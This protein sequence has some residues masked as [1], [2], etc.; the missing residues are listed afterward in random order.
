MSSKRADGEGRRG[1]SL[2]ARLAFFYTISATALLLGAM[3]ILYAAVIRHIDAEDH[4]YLRDKLRAARA[5]LLEKKA[6]A[7]P[8]LADVVP[9]G[10]SGYFVRVLDRATGLVVAE[11]PGG[12][13]KLPPSVFP[14]P[15]ADGEIPAAGVEFRTGAGQWFLLASAF[16]EIEAGARTPVL[17]QI[18]QDR[19]DDKAFTAE[20]RRLLVTVLA[21]GI[22]AAA[23]IAWL[24]AR[25][26]L[27]PLETMTRDVEKVQASHLHQRLGRGPWPA[28][29]ISLAGAF[30]EMLA[31]LEDSFARLA[32]FS[33]DLAHELRTPI[34]NL[35]GEAE[36]ALTRARTAAEYREVI[37]LGIEEYD[38]LSR[39]IDSLLFLARA[40]NAEMRIERTD[41]DAGAAIDNILDFCEASAS[42]Q[43]ITLSRTGNARLEADPALFRRVLTNLISNALAHTPA[44]GR[45][46]VS[47]R[48]PTEIA[49]AD[50]GRGI[51]P[52][53]LPR[54]FDR[55]YR[56][57]AARGAPPDG[58]GLG[59]SIV[60]SIMDL[61]GGAVTLESKL[62][63]GTTV[64]LRFPAGASR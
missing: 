34:Q 7:Q 48:S 36:V 8:L 22:A 20:F 12:G 57:D 49:V 24:V 42:E 18:A 60:K 43:N 4:A 21:G 63:E 38:R 51:S 26:G 41:F 59:L 9:A 29:L 28:E 56:A 16:A 13:E 1:W 58:T 44:G 52:E 33:A 3:L 5:D 2:V 30:D 39:M 32:R 25:R 17:L 19:S 62:D 64:T 14:A 35:R 11:R 50:T 10:D 46:N 37:E 55:F 47:V 40:E 31:R 15:R 6:G 45:V 23:G 61:H 27:R 53:H 54:I